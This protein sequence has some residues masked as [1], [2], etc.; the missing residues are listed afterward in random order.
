MRKKTATLQQV[1]N[2]RKVTKDTDREFLFL[3]QR[4]LL[5]AL[6]DLGVLTEMQYRSAEEALKKQL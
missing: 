6:K 5:L 4:A 3:Y 2:D 1:D